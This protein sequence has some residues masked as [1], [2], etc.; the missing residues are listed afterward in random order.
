VFWGLRFNNAKERDQDNDNSMQSSSW[1]A[2]LLSHITG[3]RS[4]AQ[5]EANVGQVTAHQVPSW[6]S[7]SYLQQQQKIHHDEMSKAEGC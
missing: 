1:G 4:Y 6:S 5:N 2:P 3:D 7:N